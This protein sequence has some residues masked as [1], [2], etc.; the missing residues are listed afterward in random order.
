[1]ATPSGVRPAAVSGPGGPTVAD[2]LWHESYRF[3]FFQA[4]RVLSHLVHTE[5][6]DQ[7]EAYLRGVPCRFTAHLSLGFP[8]HHIESIVAAADSQTIPTMAVNF[9]GLTG[10]SGVLPHHYTRLLLRLERQDQR[11]EA[12]ALRQ[13]LDLFNH[14]MIHLF[15]RAWEKYRVLLDL[16]KGGPDLLEPGR[17]GGNLL[18]LIGLGTQGLRDRLVVTVPPEDAEEEPT[19]AGVHDGALV[20]FVGMLA[21]R[22]RSAVNLEA[23]ARRLF[24]VPVTIRQ[25]VGNW[26]PLDPP[27]QTRLGIRAGNAVLGQTAVVGE[28]VWSVENKFRTRLG[29][30]S[31]ATFDTYLPSDPGGVRS[32]GALC[33]FVRFY[34]GAH[35]DFD[36]QLVLQAS[37]VP[38]SR[39]SSEAEEGSRLGWNSWLGPHGTPR[40]RD[41]AVF[42]EQESE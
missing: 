5:D 27:S 25:F 16:E 39:L 8:I 33:R 7:R 14:Q 20:R 13:W 6:D 42:A 28:R 26:L 4:V 23:I 32:F 3:D 31:R 37:D 41:D 21:V 38:D 11:S 17:L 10:P 24:G 12:R 40:D 29:P 36:V 30:L 19:N 18:S 1:M 34:V 2:R 35:L 22:P 15:F 9:M